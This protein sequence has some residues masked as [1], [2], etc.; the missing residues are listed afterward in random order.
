MQSDSIV[1]GLDVERRII[2]ARLKINELSIIHNHIND[3]KPVKCKKVRQ[4]FMSFL[5][6][7]ISTDASWLQKHISECP[8]CQKRMAAI[9]R[10]NLALSFIKSQSH[11]LDL[12]MR[13][14]TQTINVL[15]HSVREVPKAIK[16]KNALPRPGFSQKLIQCLQP[17]INMAACILIL[18]LMKSGIFSS[19]DEFQTQGKKA[20]KQY[21]VNRLGEEIADDIFPTDLM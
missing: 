13:A 2:M 7:Y 15:Q 4:R 9:G 6:K 1:S 5:S 19:I 8:R 12:L 14:N 16:L 11:N 3:K 18:F 17:S 21:Y 10:V 20:Y